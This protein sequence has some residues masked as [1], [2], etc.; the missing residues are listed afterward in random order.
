MTSNVFFSNFCGFESLANFPHFP[1]K[2]LL[3]QWKKLTPPSPKRMPI[4]NTLWE[5]QNDGYEEI[6]STPFRV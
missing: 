6:S 3:P 1:K 4:L 2:N 5:I